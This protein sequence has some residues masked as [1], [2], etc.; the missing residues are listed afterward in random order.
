MARSLVGF[1]QLQNFGSVCEAS[2]FYLPG[3]GR[4]AVFSNPVKFLL[5]LFDMQ[6]NDRYGLSMMQAKSITLLLPVYDDSMKT[7]K[8]SK[9]VKADFGK[10]LCSLREAAGLSQ[11]AVAKEMEISQP[12]YANWESHNVA[13]KPEQLTK[14]AKVLG[15]GV[16]ELLEDMP[17]RLR[18]SGPPGKARRLFEQVSKLPRNQQQ[19]IAGVVEDMLTAQRVSSS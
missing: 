17:S 2:R 10:R 1:Y 6:E 3:C 7:G 12:S 11:R 19:R 13:L 18:Q 5:K 8:P 4:L 9:S 16:E 14:L 15:V